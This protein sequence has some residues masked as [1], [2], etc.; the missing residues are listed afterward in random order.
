MNLAVGKSWA[1]VPVRTQKERQ[2][3]W[4]F[5]ANAAKKTL[6]CCWTS[7]HCFPLTLCLCISCPPGFRQGS[8][9]YPWLKCKLFRVGHFLKFP[10]RAWRLLKRP[11][12]C[13]D[14]PVS[15]IAASLLLYDI[16]MQELPVPA[17]HNAG[18]GS[19]CMTYEAPT[20]QMNIYSVADV[21]SNFCSDSRM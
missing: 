12:D 14:V 11:L 9:S 15:P 20:I 10:V 21:I 16:I 1:Q 17:Y 8:F 19:S 6:I 5:R 18:T 13:A 3:L 7:W 4:H 2:F